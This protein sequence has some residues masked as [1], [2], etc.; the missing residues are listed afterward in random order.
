MLNAARVLMWVNTHLDFVIMEDDCCISGY[1][2][3]ILAII[4]W[5]S[6]LR[7]L[8]LCV[9]IPSTCLLSSDSSTY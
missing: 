2:S 7:Q 6:S 8:E 1:K 9:S 3:L 4:T 5:A